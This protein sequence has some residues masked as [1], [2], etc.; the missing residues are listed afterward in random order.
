MV[1]SINQFLLEVL[2]G[3]ISE[4][5]SSVKNVLESEDVASTIACLKIRCKN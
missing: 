1:D 5:V 4:K 3:A 2:L